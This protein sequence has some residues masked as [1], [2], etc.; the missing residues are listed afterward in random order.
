M[1]D[2]SLDGDYILNDYYYVPK[3]NVFIHVDDIKLN[4]SSVT[5]QAGEKIKLKPSIT[6][7]LASNKK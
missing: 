4:E 5:L 6:P 2:S 1:L 3:E 7:E